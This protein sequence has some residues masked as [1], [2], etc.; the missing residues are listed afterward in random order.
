VS[1]DLS[2]VIACL[3]EEEALPGLF[4]ALARLAEM[5]R[6]RGIAT[7]IVFVDDGSTDGTPGI[8]AA[9]CGERAEWRVVTHERNRGFGAAMRT[10]FAAA[11]GDVLVS[12]DADATYPVEDILNLHDALD[13]YDVA[14]ATPFA[15]GGDVTAK[16][17]RVA[18]SLGVKALYSLALRRRGRGITVYTCAFRAY[19]R[20]AIRDVVNEADGFLA[21]AEMLARLLIRGARVVEVPS[22]L[23][24]R[25]AGRSKMRVVRTGL[26]HLVQIAKIALRRPPFRPAEGAT[27]IVSRVDP[28][29]LRTWN[30]ALNRDHPMAGI[31]ENPNAVIRRIEERRRREIVHLLDARPGQRVLDLGAEEGAYAKRLP[32][33]IAVDIDANVL[34]K[35]RARHGAPSVAAD[36]HGLPFRDRS[37]PRVLLAETLEHCPDPARA[38][39]EALRVVTADGRVA[40]SVPDDQRLL[41]IK[42]AIAA[43]G[44]GR[45][46]GGLPPGLAP[47]HL[48][49]FGRD[50]LV[51]LLA[52]AGRILHFSRDPA[53]LAFLAVLAPH[54]EDPPSCAASRAS[55]GSTSSPP[56]PGRS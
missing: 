6:D 41:L 12:Y 3:N 27:P 53:A 43:A 49:V 40:V 22:R 55:S 23:S 1:T 15:P 45:L 4:D 39:A 30:E 16:P 32:R 28:A 20:E 56:S 36:V 51:D 48:H 52:G 46:L 35:G 33:S 26:R 17:A 47:G 37:V 10:G 54:R 2:V 18:L 31:E 19:R 38:L 7:E 34:A 29:L 42:R 50:R 24:R 25:T 11:E 9:A 21:A 14:G 5:A 8:L 13:T 44:A